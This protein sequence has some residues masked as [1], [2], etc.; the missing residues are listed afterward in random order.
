MSELLQYG[1]DLDSIIGGR[2]SFTIGFSHC[3]ELPLQL[4][5]KVIVAYQSDDSRN[6]PSP[7]FKGGVLPA[8]A[9]A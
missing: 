3:D 8:I 2:G 4:A 7:F 1:P 6:P 5:E 9:H